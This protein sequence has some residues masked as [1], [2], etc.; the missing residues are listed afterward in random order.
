MK[1]KLLSGILALGLA[2]S[3]V[4]G[5]VVCKEYKENENYKRHLEY[6][7]KIEH[8]KLQL[9][10]IRLDYGNGSSI[11]CNVDDDPFNKNIKEYGEFCK[12]LE[13]AA[14]EQVEKLKKKLLDNQSCKKVEF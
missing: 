8:Y 9:N 1:T 3:V 10:G 11:Y 13:K 6:I 12:E 7:F 4:L 2:V 5:D 14:K